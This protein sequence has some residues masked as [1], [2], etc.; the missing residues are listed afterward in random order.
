VFLLVVDPLLTTITKD[1]NSNAETEPLFSIRSPTALRTS[2]AQSM[3]SQILK[4]FPINL[5]APMPRTTQS[6]L[7]QDTLETC[8][9]AMMTATETLAAL[10][11]SVHPPL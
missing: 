8:V 1:L 6:S 4:E 2:L 10:M 3:D 9:E 7:N 5:L 11:E